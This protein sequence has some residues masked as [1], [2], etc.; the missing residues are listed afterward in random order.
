MIGSMRGI[1]E[2]IRE[3]INSR[4]MMD[5]N[6]VMVRDRVIDKWIDTNK[7]RTINPILIIIPKTLIR[8]IIS[9]IRLI[10]PID[11]ISL[12]SLITPISPISPIDP[13]KPHPLTLTITTTSIYPLTIPI[14]NPL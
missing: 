4:S 5:G 10:A 11:P 3:G 12:I 13:P 8:L 2:G 1:R 7:H 6:R 9:P 14:I